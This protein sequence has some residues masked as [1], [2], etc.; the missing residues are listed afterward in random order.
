MDNMP[1][2][3]ENAMEDLLKSMTDPN[4]NF[5]TWENNFDLKEI[6]K[7][8]KPDDTWK[9][10]TAY[11]NIKNPYVAHCTPNNPCGEV[12]LE[13]LPKPKRYTATATF[14]PPPIF[15]KE[16]EKRGLKFTVGKEY[17]IIAEVPEENQA[18][19]HRCIVEDDDGSRRSLNAVHFVWPIFK[20]PSNY[21]IDINMA[22]PYNCSSSSSTSASTYSS[23]FSSTSSSSSSS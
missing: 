15:L 5:Q 18:A 2:G 21:T 4:A 20:E 1:E 19:G 8:K 16:V 12:A 14:N 3:Y 23:A 22:S 17:T 7:E 13:K 10:R 6:T 11:P 9:H